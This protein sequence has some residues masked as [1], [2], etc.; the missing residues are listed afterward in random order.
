VAIALDTAIPPRRLG[1][2]LRRARR[3]SGLRRAAAAARLGVSP[4]L[5]VAW[6]RGALRVPDDTITPLVDLYGEHLTA[7]VPAR[8][9]V[10]VDLG[11]IAVGWKITVLASTAHDDVLAAYVELLRAVRDAKP[12]EAV[13]LRT[14]DLEVLAA[15]IGAD[16]GDVEARIVELLRCTNAEARTLHDELRRRTLLV[17]AAGLA[18]GAAAIT[19]MVATAPGSSGAPPAAHAAATPATAP[20]ARTTTSSTTTPPST[21]PGSTPATTLPVAPAAPATAE[22]SAAPPVTTTTTT[23]PAT[24]PPATTPPTTSAPVTAARAP[25]ANDP[26]VAIPEGETPTIVQP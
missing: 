17:P 20:V 18:L 3:A 24:T 9:P 21:T 8:E 26:P 22:A 13:A 6:E 14:S 16:T 25:E 19:G 11:Q 1:R 23:P 10:A 5:L 2:A 7:L 4:R 12:G 15:A